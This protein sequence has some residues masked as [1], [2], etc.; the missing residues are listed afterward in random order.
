VRDRPTDTE[1]GLSV[2]DAAEFGSERKPPDDR[3]APWLQA[4]CPIRRCESRKRLVTLW[5]VIDRPAGGRLG[6]RL[7]NHDGGVRVESQQGQEVGDDGAA[8]AIASPLRGEMH[9]VD[10]KD[11][12]DECVGMGIDDRGCCRTELFGSELMASAA[13]RRSSSSI[14]H[15]IQPLT[16]P[17]S[18]GPDSTL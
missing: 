17:I 8:Q 6:L 2:S 13:S 7:E 4:T 11:V 12:V 9:A 3:L 15:P 5:P 16:K 10:Q 18:S 14:R 1:V